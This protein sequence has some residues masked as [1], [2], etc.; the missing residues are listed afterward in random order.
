MS[1]T[2]WRLNPLLRWLKVAGP[3]DEDKTMRLRSSA[4]D[5]P[6]AKGEGGKTVDKQDQDKYQVRQDRGQVRQDR[7]ET[8]A[9]DA[10]RVEPA[11]E[12]EGLRSDT[13]VG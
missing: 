4:S 5:K 9:E 8:E 1:K 13:P 7:G 11:S 12:S 2:L 10:Q 3:G 6:N